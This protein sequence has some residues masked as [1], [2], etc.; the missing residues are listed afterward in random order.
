MHFEKEQLPTHAEKVW[1]EERCWVEFFTR[2]AR[3]QQFFRSCCILV[4]SGKPPIAD[5]AEAK[6][7][8]AVTTHFVQVAPQSADLDSQL[9]RFWELEGVRATTKP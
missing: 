7:K 8:L 3:I 5:S 6:P 9:K 1:A 4:F 2:T